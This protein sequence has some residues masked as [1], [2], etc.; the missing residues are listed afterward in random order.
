MNIYLYVKTHNVTGLKYLGKTKQ[1]PYKYKGSG[2]YWTN[3]IEK[4]GYNVTTEV[5]GIFQSNQEL[6]KVSKVLSETWNIVESNQ[7]ANLK[8]ELGDGGPGPFNQEANKKNASLG[9]ISKAAKKYPAW[10]KGIPTPR[11]Q[12][13]IEKQRSTMTGKK[14]GP[15][16]LKKHQQTQLPSSSPQACGAGWHQ[17]KPKSDGCLPSDQERGRSSR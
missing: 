5:I 13:S 17:T 14:R 9:G 3:H 6:V 10:N 11:S 2:K 1:D 4:H 15:Y 16:N 8:L 7:W 12:K